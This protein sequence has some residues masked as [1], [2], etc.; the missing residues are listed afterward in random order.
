MSPLS[1]A[2]TTVT[3][4]HARE[5]VNKVISR[6]TVSALIHPTSPLPTLVTPTRRSTI[7]ETFLVLSGSGGRTTFDTASFL[8]ARQALAGPLFL[9]ACWHAGAHKSP[10][11]HLSS[12]A[13]FGE[14]VK[15][16]ED[17]LPPSPLPYACW[18]ADAYRENRPLSIHVCACRHVGAHACYKKS[19]A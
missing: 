13:T 10:H 2:A 12:H 3:V 9:C 5:G 1:S 17:L 18:H 7:L 4:G 16:N 14:R 6:K 11:L 8:P 15:S 19:T